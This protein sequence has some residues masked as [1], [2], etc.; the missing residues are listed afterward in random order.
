MNPVIDTIL[1]HVP[2]LGFKDEI[3]NLFASGIEGATE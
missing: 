2:N 1:T 3:H